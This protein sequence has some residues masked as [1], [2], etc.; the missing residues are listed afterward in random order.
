MEKRARSE[1]QE[2]KQRWKSV[3]IA[4]T[5]VVTTLA[6]VMMEG[7]KIPWFLGE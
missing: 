2:K 1:K 5:G 4:S 3:A 7:P 6:V